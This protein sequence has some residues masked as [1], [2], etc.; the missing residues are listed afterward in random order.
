MKFTYYILTLTLSL[1]SVNGYC[2]N[3]EKSKSTAYT[4]AYGSNGIC[5]TNI[6]VT[7]KVRLTT[8]DDGYPAWSPDGKRIA[9]YGY[10]DGKKTWSIHTIDSDGTNR[11]R[12]THAKN[13]WDS[14]PSWSPDGKKIV[15]AREYKDLEGI[16]RYEIWIINSDGNRQIQIKSLKGSNPYFTPD[17]RIAFSAEFKDKDS[18]ISIA[19]VDGR[20]IIQLTDNDSNEWHPKVSPDGKQVAF[21]SNRD[22]YHEI[23]IMNIDG[24]NQKRLTNN[25]VGDYGP[26]WSPGGSQLVFQSMGK[27]RVRKLI[28]IL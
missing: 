4:I 8:G 27:R 28:F 3:S 22:G 5:L 9:M 10:H 23:Y 20:N 19:D 2:Q 16:W 25:D 12:L 26:S 7:S 24:S 13:K 11:K 1:L 14:T 21:S 15:F 17:G 6:E 18:E